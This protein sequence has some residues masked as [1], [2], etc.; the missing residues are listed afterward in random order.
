MEDTL[1]KKYT[2]D[3]R[4]LDR[5]W[6]LDR[7]FEDKHESIAIEEL[8]LSV[9]VNTNVKKGPLDLQR[10]DALET[11]ESRIKERCERKQFSPLFVDD[12]IEA[13]ELARGLAGR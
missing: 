10:D 5:S 13:A 9:P 4:I 8:R 2:L 11:L 3:V 12:C 1:S 6:I 7:V